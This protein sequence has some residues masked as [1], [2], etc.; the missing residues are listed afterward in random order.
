MKGKLKDYEAAVAR[1]KAAR[2][3]YE[4]EIDTLIASMKPVVSTIEKKPQLLQ[5]FRWIIN[6]ISAFKF[7]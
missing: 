6:Q 1:F 2:A 3:E 4:K 7:R 5:E